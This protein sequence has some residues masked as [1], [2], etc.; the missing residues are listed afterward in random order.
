MSSFEYRGGALHAEDVSLTNLAEK[1]GTPFY[2]YSAEMLR[3]AYTDFAGAFAGLDVTVCYAVK[4]NSNQ[5]VIALFAALGA[6]ADVVSEGELRRALAAGVPADKIVF[7]GVG[8]TAEEIR[9]ALDGGIRQFNVESE[10]E[11]AVLDLM[12]RQMGVIAPITIRVNPDVD[13]KTHAKI[14]TGKSENKFGIPIARARPSARALSRALYLRQP[15]SSCVRR[16]R[17]VGGQ[18]EQGGYL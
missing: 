4:A 15:T 6:G 7:S 1:V 16:T 8:K 12:A 14:A 17:G 5:A 11:M 9:L 13:A 3:K 10:P 2:C 18:R